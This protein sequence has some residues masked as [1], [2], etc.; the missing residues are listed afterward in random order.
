MFYSALFVTSRIFRLKYS[1]TLVRRTP[2][3]ILIISKPT[4]SIHCNSTNIVELTNSLWGTWKKRMK[5]WI[6]YWESEILHTEEFNLKYMSLIYEVSHC[7]ESRRTPFPPSFLVV[8]HILSCGVISAIVL[9]LQG[10]FDSPALK[11][12]RRRRWSQQVSVTLLSH[13]AIKGK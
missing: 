5:V 3:V 4:W 1:N 8:I 2:K 12:S 6:S 11:L 9:I 7:P 10:C 13:I